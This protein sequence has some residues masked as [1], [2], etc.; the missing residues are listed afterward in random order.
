MCSKIRTAGCFRLASLPNSLTNWLND[1]GR[2]KMRHHAHEKLNLPARFSCDLRFQ[3]VRERDEK[4][5]CMFR[6]YKVLIDVCGAVIGLVIYFT[7]NRRKP[8]GNLLQPGDLLRDRQSKTL[9]SNNQFYPTILSASTIY[10][11]LDRAELISVPSDLQSNIRHTHLLKQRRR[12]PS[13]VEEVVSKS[14]GR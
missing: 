11:M 3:P 7:L 6:R 1:L 10:E 5:R 8:A 9:R 4:T 2:R 14:C 12:M 13:Y